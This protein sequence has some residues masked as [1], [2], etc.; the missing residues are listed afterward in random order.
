MHFLSDLHASLSVQTP[1]NTN[2]RVMQAVDFV[3]FDHALLEKSPFDL[4]GGEKRRAAIAGVIAMDQMCIR[5]SF[6]RA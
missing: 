6:N 4:S 3:G 5:D 2:Q 1:Y